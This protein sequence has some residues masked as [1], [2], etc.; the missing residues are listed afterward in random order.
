M[1][2][3]DA[4]GLGWIDD[5][6]VNPEG[7]NMHYINGRE[8]KEGDSIIAYE[9]YAKRVKVGVVHSLNAQATTCNGQITIV[10]PGGVQH[11][12]VTLGECIHAEDA[13]AAAVPEPPIG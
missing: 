1:K 8:A 3:Q 7:A 10:V 13:F 12:S 4:G 9:K 2:R 5:F 11:H 6:P